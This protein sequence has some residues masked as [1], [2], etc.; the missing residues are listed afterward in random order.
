[1]TALAEGPVAAFTRPARPSE[2][3]PTFEALTAYHFPVGIFL[4]SIARPG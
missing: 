3:P 4:V 1:M 2:L